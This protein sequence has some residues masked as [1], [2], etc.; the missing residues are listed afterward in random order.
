M[1]RLGTETGSLINNIMSR[2]VIGAPAPTIGMGATKLSWSDRH[3]ATICS[4]EVKNGVTIIGVQ[5]DDY[6][7]TDNNGM[8]ESQS[9]EFTP[10]PNAHV[11][12]FRTT[13]YGTWEAIYRNPETNRWKKGCGSIKVGERDKFYDFSF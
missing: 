5:E 1:L 8:S 7:R 12:Y 13:K 4:V 2:Q 11:E 6:I 10:Q 9:Y 3:P